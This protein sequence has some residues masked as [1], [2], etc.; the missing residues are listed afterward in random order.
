MT[1]IKSGLTTRDY[2]LIIPI[3]KSMSD[4]DRASAAAVNLD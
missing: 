3:Y 2:G 4:G 1:K